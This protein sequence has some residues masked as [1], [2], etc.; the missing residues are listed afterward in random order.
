MFAGTSTFWCVSHVIGL[1]CDLTL[2]LLLKMQELQ[3]VL[4]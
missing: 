2:Y 1:G 4:C 3:L